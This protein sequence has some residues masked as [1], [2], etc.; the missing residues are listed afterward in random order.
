MASWDDLTAELDL[1]QK[2]G[3]PATFWWRDDDLNEPTAAFDRL[4]S[5]RE[6]FDIPLTLAVIPDEVDPHIADDLGGCLLVQHGV[7]HRSFAQEGE[8]KSEFPETRDLEEALDNLGVGRHRMET[9]FE[10]HF[11]PV[12]VPPW[13]RVGEGVVSA[14]AD[15]GFIGL[16]RYKARGQDKVSGG[17]VAE[18]N[19]HVD[20]IFWRGH[21]SAL[22]DE[23]VLDQVLDHLKGRRLGKYDAA[24]PTGIL[25]HH[26]VH[27]EA[28][29]QLLFQL[30]SFLNSHPIVRW[31]TYPGAMSLIDDLPDDI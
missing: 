25:S 19:T 26:L 24:E 31:L 10:D 27:D 13:N 21:R 18:I 3:T 16:S 20:P 7:V 11:L 6:Q 5:L 22:Q 23:I 17:R 9:L 14:L 4:L 30:F 29:W 2:I 15:R 8:K 1:W 28:I 12:F